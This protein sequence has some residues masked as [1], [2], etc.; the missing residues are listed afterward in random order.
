M[1]VGTEGRPVLVDSVAAATAAGVK[2]ATLRGWAHR[3][4]LERK[5]TD[6]KGRAVYDLADVYR[7][8]G[9]VRYPRGLNVQQ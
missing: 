3:G 6:S 8:A 5:G 7:T 1:T 9:A 4:L 2:P